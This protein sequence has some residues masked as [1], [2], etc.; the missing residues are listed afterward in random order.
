MLVENSAYE[1]LS[2][3]VSQNQAN[4]R[5]TYARYA[6]NSENGHLEQIRL[7]FIRTVRTYKEHHDGSAHVQSNRKPSAT[8]WLEQDFQPRIATDR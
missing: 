4:L 6:D 2:T 5:G 3:G 8:N 1:K 7:G